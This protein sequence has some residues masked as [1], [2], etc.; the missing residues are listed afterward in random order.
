MDT[1]RLRRPTG[2]PPFIFGHRGVRGEAPENTMSAFELAAD[3][4]ADGIELDVRLCRSGDVVVCHDPTLARATGGRD[5][6]AVAD[7]DLAELSAVDLGGGQPVPLLKE[8]LAWARAKD[9]AVNV[10]MK[11]DLPNRPKA[12]RATAKVLRSVPSS[13]VIVSSFDP[14]ML[15]Y[16]G[17]LLPDVPRGCLFASDQKYLMLQTSGWVAAAVRASAV[18]P[19]KT[20][21]SVDRC[22]K[23]KKHGNL[24]NVWTVNDVA[25]GREL[26]EMGV[27]AIITDVPRDMVR[28]L[29]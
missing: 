16:F 13:G 26:A 20:L 9:L 3:S 8:V 24:I 17:W 21:V 6:R 5:V 29:K 28:A 12:V 4:G 25:K 15:A 1:S 23:W 22:R 11:R 14:W 7:L 10:E 19:E 2:A 27:D 18:H